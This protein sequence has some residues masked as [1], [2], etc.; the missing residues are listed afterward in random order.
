MTDENLFDY[1]V[2]ILNAW[3][4]NLFGDS[5]IWSDETKRKTNIVP[6][7]A[8]RRSEATRR[9]QVA[10]RRNAKPILSHIRRLDDLK[11]RDEHK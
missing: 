10:M 2:T 7:S 5:T 11:R 6:H 8:T 3:G 1:A 4:R 9:T